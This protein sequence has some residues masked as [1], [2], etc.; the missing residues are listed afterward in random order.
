MADVHSS[1]AT[2]TALVKAALD[3]EIRGA[4]RH[5]PVWRSLAD[6]R[7]S[8]VNMPG[9]SVDIYRYPDMAVS[10]TPLNEVTDPDF[11]GLGNPTAVTIPL[12]EYGNV[13]NLTI[14][15]MKFAFSDIQPYQ[16]A[17]IAWNMRDTI[18]ELVRDAL[19]LG[20]QV[21]YGGSATSTVTVAAASTIDS[22]DVRRAVAKLRA[23]AVQE[24]IGN[25]LYQGFIHPD[26]SHDLRSATGAG[27][28]QDVHKYA[29]P[30]LIWPGTVGV[31]EGVY[32]V[33]TGRARLR[34][35]AGATNANVHDTLIFGK[36]AL[37]E[38]VAKEF[39]PEVGTISDKL[40]RFL[41]VGWHG[42]GGWKVFREEALYRL[43]TS[44][45]IGNNGV[46]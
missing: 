44:S 1:T 23:Q 26:V 2:L 8:Q 22:Q 34:V 39:Q 41:P 28:W 14:R 32:F 37:A 42:I 31:Y 25:E 40:N 20:T 24:R 9:S 45:S 21:A 36:E 11:V 12:N 4:L 46:G 35:D 43:E 38:A 6:V 18:D 13:T 16:L 7:P 5:S 17:Q 27:E 30:D 19:S 10:K 15:A 29:A 33:E 3:R